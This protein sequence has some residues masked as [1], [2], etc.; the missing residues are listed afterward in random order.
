MMGWKAEERTVELPGSS[1]SG[2]FRKRTVGKKAPAAPT[3]TPAPE[4]APAETTTPAPMP[5]AAGADPFAG[6]AADPF[7]APAPKPMPKPMPAA[8]EADPFGTP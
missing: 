1:G 2:E 7:S 6:G 4:G 5:P 3:T 8:G